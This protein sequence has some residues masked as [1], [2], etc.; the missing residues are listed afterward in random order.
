VYSASVLIPSRTL[1]CPALTSWPAPAPARSPLSHSR[2]HSPPA[3]QRSLGNSC[4]ALVGA[5]NT[6]GRRHQHTQFVSSVEEAV[7]SFRLTLSCEQ[8][9]MRFGPFLS[10][11]DAIGDEISWRKFTLTDV[12][13]GHCNAIDKQ[14]RVIG[15]CSSNTLRSNRPRSR[16][17]TARMSDRS[18]K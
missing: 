18:S 2:K 5:R 17:T 9:E 6:G 7:G 14:I 12:C 3:R 10:L 13:T 1:T 4:S 11:G 15:A 16:T 8:I